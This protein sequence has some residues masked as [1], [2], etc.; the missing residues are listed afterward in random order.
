MRVKTSPL[1]EIARVLVRL[2]H[3]ASI[4]VHADGTSID[5]RVNFTAWQTRDTRA[6]HIILSLPC[7]DEKR[8]NPAA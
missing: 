2:N 5:S 8:Q 6:V 7:G 1:F 4:I 3:V